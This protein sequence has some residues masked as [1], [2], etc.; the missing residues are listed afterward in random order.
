MKNLHPQWPERN[1]GSVKK[2]S[3]ARPFNESSDPLIDRRM[4]AD[5]AMDELELEGPS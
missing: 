2:R 5:I 4:D 1:E 3:K